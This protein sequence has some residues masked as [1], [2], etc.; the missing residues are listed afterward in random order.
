MDYYLRM[1]LESGARM[2]VHATFAPVIEKSISQND[3]AKF[4]E[5]TP[6]ADQSAQIEVKNLTMRYRDDLPPVLNDI[7]FTVKPGEQL[8]IIGRTGSGKSSLIQALFGLYPFEKGI[9]TLGGVSPDLAKT[10]S[11]AIDLNARGE[12]PLTEFRRRM[13]L[14]PQEPNL[15][16]GTIRENLS[17]VNNLDDGKLWTALEKIGIAK[18]VRSLKHHGQTGLDFRLEEG[19]KNISQGERQLFCMARAL[20]QDTPII[21]MDE[22]TSS[23]DPASEELLVRATETHMKEKTKIIVA[24]RLSTI[25]TSDRVMWL[26]HGRIRMLDRPEVVLPEFQL[27]ADQS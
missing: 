14:I 11:L 23:V 19:A 16:R 2:P 12:I 9:I 22:A 25:E 10:S 24:H 26:D 13:A 6:K 15:F 18:W 27:K 8:A 4:G 20:L 7:N 1:P 3:L 17:G 21:I 5:P